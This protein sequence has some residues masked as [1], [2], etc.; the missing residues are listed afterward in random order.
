MATALRQLW[1][2]LFLLPGLL[3]LLVAF[4][5]PAGQGTFRAWCATYWWQLIFLGSLAYFAAVFVRRAL[6]WMGRRAHRPD[7]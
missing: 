1:P 2:A 7:A 5:A 3:A 6:S 4:L